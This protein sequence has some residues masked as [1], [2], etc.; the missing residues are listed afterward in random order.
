MQALETIYNFRLLPNGIGTSGQPTA[1][2]FAA[3]AAKGYRRVIN[4]ALSTSTNAI[5]NEREI[6]ES[7]GLEYIHIPVVWEA[8]TLEDLQAF[9]EAMQSQPEKKPFV[10]CAANMRVS[11]FMYLY[12]VLQTSDDRAA[13]WQDVCPIWTPNPTWQT[14]IETAIAHY[15]PES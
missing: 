6:V 3:I 15:Q 5:A 10:H 2:Q 1:E 13:A 12:R 9:F 4:L 14:F 11:A 7:N 8:P